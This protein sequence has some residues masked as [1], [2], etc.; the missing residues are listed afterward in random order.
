MN[1]KYDITIKV[2]TPIHIWDWNTL[3]GLNYFCYQ[4]RIKKKEEKENDCDKTH[5]SWLYKFDIE[6]FVSI[7]DDQDKQKFTQILKWWEVGEIRW[8]IYKCLESEWKMK[9]KKKVFIDND[10]YKEKF[11]A[12]P[13]IQKT[14][15][16]NTFYTHWKEK[17]LWTGWQ[18]NGKSSEA[19]LEE[20]KNQQSQMQI[21][22][23]IH[24]MWRYYIPWSSLKWA[25]RTVL[26]NKEIE[27]NFKNH[28]VNKDPFKKL[29]VQDSEFLSNED[30]FIDSLARMWSQQWKNKQWNGQFAQFIKPDTTTQTTI[31]IKNFLDESNLITRDF[32]TKNICIQANN[33][34]TSKIKKYNKEIDKLL[35]HRDL[36]NW[37]IASKKKKEKLNTVKKGF[38]DIL[39]EI[40][41]CDDNE[42]IVSIGYWTGYWFK[43]IS[44]IQEHHPWKNQKN[45]IDPSIQISRTNRTTNLQNLGFIKLTFTS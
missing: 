7:L 39:K 40:Q 29:I 20:K 35:L 8:F 42:C 23:F 34:L 44:D 21:K 36:Q 16:T 13:T 12:L 30:I 1:K 11:L 5:I 33:Y 22:T 3:S 25:L 18:S 15:T 32:S 10:K 4:E 2:L 14:K 37:N 41:N 45:L 31:A 43:M 28:K 26:S 9:W 24:S 6:D 17:I 38:K 27:E 19:L